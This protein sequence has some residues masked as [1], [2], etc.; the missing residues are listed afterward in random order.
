VFAELLG[1]P[2]VIERAL[3]RSSFGFMAFHGGLEEGTDLIAERAAGAAG[4]SL[5]SVVQPPD[6]LWHVPSA[7]V[8][9]AA[10]PRLAGFLDHVEVVV[11]VHGY[12]RRGRPSD[13][14]LGGRNRALATDLG[15]RLREATTGLQIVDDLDAIPL[16]LRGLHPANPVNQPP[17]AGVQLELPP[18]ARGS[19]ADPRLRGQGANPVA[20]VVE[21][22]VITALEWTA[23]RRPPSRQ[24]SPGGPGAPSS[25]TH[26]AA[27]AQPTSKVPPARQ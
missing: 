10:S 6:L 5:Y 15:R 19:S 13:V 9:A 4:A 21:G 1:Q 26:P 2:G 22:L 8:S 23:A 17:H 3:L 12:G 11:A 27:S 7:L 18:R 20:G 16:E 14:L 25:T 24:A